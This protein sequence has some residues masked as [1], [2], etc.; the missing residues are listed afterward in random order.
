MSCGFD[1]LLTMCVSCC[2]CQSRQDT[3]AWKDVLSRSET[4]LQHFLGD[5]TTL[6][7]ILQLCQ[8]DKNNASSQQTLDGKRASAR[9]SR[10]PVVELY[11]RL[12]VEHLTDR[13]MR[14]AFP[15]SSVYD[16]SVR[17][18]RRLIRVSTPL[19]KVG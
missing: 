11:D 3:K 16:L 15:K 5:K 19:V 14:A 2:T 9:S 13:E 8:V 7:K 17:H 6:K 18:R 1:S 12:G 10:H 4:T